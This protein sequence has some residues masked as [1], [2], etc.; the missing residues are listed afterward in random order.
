M[1]GVLIKGRNLDIEIWD[2][3]RSPCVDEGTDRADASKAK[4]HQ[5]A[6]AELRNQEEARK[7]PSS[8]PHRDPT[9]LTP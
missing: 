3:E 8:R 9:L 7:D 5:R 4:K 2:A 6:P 1:T